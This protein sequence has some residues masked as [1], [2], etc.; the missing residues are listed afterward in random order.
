AAPGNPVARGPAR[1]WN[2]VTRA[3]A[4]VWRG[5]VDGY[6][7]SL[8][9]V[10]DHAGLM[11]LLLLVTIGLNVYLYTIVPKGFFPQQDT[12][13]LSG[14]IQADQGISFQSMEKKLETFVS[15]VGRDPAVA[16]VVGFTG[17]GQRNSASMFITL[18]PLAERGAMTSDQVIARLRPQLARE[19]GARLFLQST[20]ELRAGG[21]SGA[22]QYQYTLQADELAV[23]RAWEPRVRLA[24]AELPEITD[25][26]TDTQDR[27][28]QTSVIV[29]RDA[30]ARLG[31]DMRRISASLNNAFGQRQVS[32]IYNPLNQYRV[33]MEVAPRYWQSPE[34]LRD[35]VF[36]TAD[37]RSIPLASIATFGP[38][39][40]PLAVNHQSGFAASTLSFNLPVGGSLSSARE[41][42]SG[43]LAR[44]GAPSTLQGGFQGT[45]RLFTSS[46]ESQPWLIL[47]AF[48][49]MYIVLGILYESTL[50]P[51]TILSTLP[52]AGV[53]ALLALMI[54]KSE[55]NIIALIGVLLLIGI[56]KKNAIMMIDFALDAQRRRGLS[57]R[58]AIEEACR[59]RLR[60]ILMT[61]MAALLGA[62]PLA[63]GSGDGAELRQPLGIAIVGG[64]VVSQ[65]LTL[66][67]TPVVYLH[68]D[69][70]RD[71]FLRR[72]ASLRAWR[73]RSQVP[74]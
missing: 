1:A 9:W 27:G 22:A 2:S 72:R 16:T 39:N 10:L 35:F 38:T 66:Y 14:S 54:A 51:V 32:T 21:R 61:T 67:T 43:T 17:G 28:E 23:L 63:L 25:V 58:A 34:I 52:S 15:I 5:V 29:D 65:V 44:I 3:S 60:P 30:A 71:F 50:H 40:T 68:L 13:R 24:L 45:A 74:A 36:V 33:V 4:R 20:Q 19:P 49:A 37:G 31:L 62:L 59:L 12:G 47:A 70:M 46:F 26:N 8:S 53:G 18:K 42:I 57:P 69:R 7:S 41:A 11:L 55:F 6:S 48:V 64:L 73:T 56:V